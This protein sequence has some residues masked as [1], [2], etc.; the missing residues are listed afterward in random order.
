MSEPKKVGRRTFLN[1]AIAVVATGV[2]VGA[3]TYLAVPKEVT[4]TTKTVT[5][6]VTGTPT[7]TSTM[8]PKPEKL[9]LLVSAGAAEPDF[10]CRDASPLFTMKY[11]IPIEYTQVPWDGLR[12]KIVTNLVGETGAFDVM[13]IYEGWLPQL[14]EYLEP[15]DQW[16]TDEDRKDYVEAALS[17][18]SYEGV[19]YGL[20]KYLECRTI[21]YNK[22]MFEK[23]KLSIPKTWSEFIDVAKTL[24]TDGVYGFLF[25]A[26]KAYIPGV[27]EQFAWT[28]G[29]GT[30]E[31]DE[32]GFVKKPFKITIDSKE[33]IETMYLLRD[34]ILT[35]KT[36]PKDVMVWGHAPLCDE[37][38]SER[39]AM[40]TLWPYQQPL[41]ND[42]EK[43][44]VIGKWGIFDLP[45]D[46]K[47]KCSV[48]SSSIGFCIP[49]ASKNKRWAFEF[50]RFITGPEVQELIA[51]KINLAPVRYS[52]YEKVKDDPVIG[53][54]IKGWFKANE[55][56][57]PEGCFIPEWPQIADEVAIG[58]QTI[59]AGEKDAEVVCNELAAK[60]ATILKI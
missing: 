46:P 23:Y 17:R 15:I 20:P 40:A 8:P 26:G 33:S 53:D 49:K 22:E 3:A 39:A 44:K 45:L 16:L 7:M 12:D 21:I 24:T 19:Q 25:P 27:F 54:I 43:S 31:R 60:I 57:W 32:H 59:M 55:R 50:A 14:V 10:Y 37:F 30:L 35:W 13:G 34:F 47:G 58:C 51:R 41:L 56:S 9:T 5:T 52:S 4:T 2:I 48:M 6:T 42:P 29:G 11:G 38:I 18:S 36:T 28:K 1:Y